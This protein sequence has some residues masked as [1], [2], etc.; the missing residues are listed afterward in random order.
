[1]KDISTFVF[2]NNRE[3]DRILD[4]IYS[5]GITSLTNKETE[6][7][8]AVSNNRTIK[9]PITEWETSINDIPFKFEYTKSAINKR[10]ERLEI[11]GELYIMG[12]RF[13]GEFEGRKKLDTFTF[14]KDGK[15]YEYVT[16]DNLINWF[17]SV[18]KINMFSKSDSVKSFPIWEWFS[19]IYTYYYNEF[20]S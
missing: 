18:M 4:K 2:E 16:S 15:E 6:Y 14:M 20:D 11:S 9:E 17:G 8:D 12:K 1:M 5:K 13:V 3:L 10:Y 7:L 19:D